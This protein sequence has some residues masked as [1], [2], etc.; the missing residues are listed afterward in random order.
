[1]ELKQAYF[2]LPNINK[3]KILNDVSL[4]FIFIKANE[5]RH[6]FEIDIENNIE[7]R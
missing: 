5:P 4:S 7:K 6:N 2:S 3:K 1:M